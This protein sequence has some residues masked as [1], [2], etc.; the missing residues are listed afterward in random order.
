[1]QNA[2]AGSLLRS[3]ELENWTARNPKGSIR[4]INSLQGL[5]ELDARDWLAG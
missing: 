5:L 4:G 3:I 1:M 2:R